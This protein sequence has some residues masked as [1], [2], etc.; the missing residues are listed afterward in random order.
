M[1]TK[2]TGLII[3]QNKSTNWSS[4][5]ILPAERYKMKTVKKI[6]TVCDIEYIFY[7]SKK[8]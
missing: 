4:R 7:Y 3:V 8:T 5:F 6:C 1:K 2:I